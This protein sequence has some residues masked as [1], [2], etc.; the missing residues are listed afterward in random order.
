MTSLHNDIFSKKPDINVPLARYRTYVTIK[1]TP[2]PSSDGMD[3]DQNV[4]GRN[5]ES[6]SA[7]VLDEEHLILVTVTW[8]DIAV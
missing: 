6:D 8:N 4:T 3:T 7:R 2:D 1:I 5:T